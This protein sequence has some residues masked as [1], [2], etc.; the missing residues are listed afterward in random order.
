MHHVKL[1]L[2]VPLASGCVVQ[3]TQPATTVTASWTLAELATGQATGCPDGFSIARLI[4]QPSEG[5]DPIATDLDCAAGL[6]VSAALSPGPYDLAIEIL[7][8]DGT[9]YARSTPRTLDLTDGNSERFDATILDDAGYLQLAWTLV[10]ATGTPRTCADGGGVDHV[11]VTATGAAGTFQD[12][13]TCEAHGGLT[14]AL[15]VGDYAFT[16]AAERSN[17]SL[18]MVTDLSSRS[19][20]DRNR[21]TDLGSIE[22]PIAG[23]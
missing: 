23:P 4:A 6:G 18:G 7:A 22:V 14:H 15:P 5:G 8:A 11:I 16:V 1:L 20:E 21:I 12:R 13:F 10:G 9:R 17:Q 19:I 3:A 2:V